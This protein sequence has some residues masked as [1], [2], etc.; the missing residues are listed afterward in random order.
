MQRHGYVL[1]ILL[2]IT[3][4]IIAI[5]EQYNRNVRRID[6]IRT[7]IDSYGA[8]EKN[9]TAYPNV[10]VKELQTREGGWVPD[11]NGLVCRSAEFSCVKNKRYNLKNTTKFVMQDGSAFPAISE[12]P[13]IAIIGD[14]Y[15]R[16]LYE[17]LLCQ[18]SADSDVHL[19]SPQ[20][21]CTR[22][23]WRHRHVNHRVQHAQH[24]NVQ[25]NVSYTWAPF[26]VKA[27]VK[28]VLKKGQA[29]HERLVITNASD[30][31]GHEELRRFEYLNDQNSLVILYAEHHW[32]SSWYTY[33]NSDKWRWQKDPGYVKLL[34]LEARKTVNRYFAERG[35]YQVVEL[36]TDKVENIQLGYTYEIPKNI[37]TPPLDW[38]PEVNKHWCT[39]IITTAVLKS[40]LSVYDGALAADKTASHH[41]VSWLSG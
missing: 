9:S 10:F 31:L 18:L 28:T 8:L 32:Y 40:I 23:C 25:F 41:R 20:P 4:I 16:A 39:E 19:D 36:T 12:Y 11:R 3:F 30:F 22:T 38:V 7:L 5:S 6:S 27:E 1:A 17:A 34:K 29:G 14:S 37:L 15:A 26:F 21:N 13:N 35:Y 24:V 33:W 2:S